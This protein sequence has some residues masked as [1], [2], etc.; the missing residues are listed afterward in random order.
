LKI[1]NKEYINKITVYC[2]ES[3]RLETIEKLSEQGFDVEDEFQLKSNEAMITASKKVIIKYKEPLGRALSEIDAARFLSKTMNNIKDD[4]DFKPKLVTSTIAE[5]PVVVSFFSRNIGE[6]ILIYIE[7]VDG[8]H[9]AVGY[10]E[11]I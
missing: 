10:S 2:D 11:E 5:H 7:E 6:R 1:I 3:E 4:D 9:R 8:F